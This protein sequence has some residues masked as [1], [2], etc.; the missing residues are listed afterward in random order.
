MF[1][2]ND[3]NVEIVFLI[4]G[5]LHRKT[6]DDLTATPCLGDDDRSFA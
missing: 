6:V 3:T 5:S 1:G 4:L 2:W